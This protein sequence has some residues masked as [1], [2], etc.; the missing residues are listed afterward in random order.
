MSAH[1]KVCVGDPAEEIIVVLHSH[2]N[3]VAIRNEKLRPDGC[4]ANRQER[5]QPMLLPQANCEGAPVAREWAAA[6]E[7]AG[8]HPHGA[9]V[10]HGT[11]AYR[12][13]S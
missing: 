6:R 12:G 3:I 11:A 13:Q 9:T 10:I 5:D 4:E 7:A 2:I 8:D 1:P